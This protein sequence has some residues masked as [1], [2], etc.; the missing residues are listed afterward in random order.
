[1]ARRIKTHVV[2]KNCNYEVARIGCHGME[3]RY[4]MFCQAEI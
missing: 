3:Y 2:C 1:M 4:C